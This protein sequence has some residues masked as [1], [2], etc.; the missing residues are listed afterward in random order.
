MLHVDL[1]ILHAHGIVS[2]KMTSCVAY[3]K[4]IKIGAK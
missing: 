1:Y 4:K 3:V 2:R